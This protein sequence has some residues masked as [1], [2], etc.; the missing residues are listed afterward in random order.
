MISFVPTPVN[1]LW[2]AAICH[3]KIITDGKEHIFEHLRG[4]IIIEKEN[5]IWK[6]SH[7]HASFPD[8]RNAENQSFPMTS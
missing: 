3:A 7:M 6:I 1:S 4:T 2:V 5:D 8:Y